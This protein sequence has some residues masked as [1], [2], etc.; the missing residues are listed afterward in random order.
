MV[1]KEGEKG[2]DVGMSAG[3]ENLEFVEELGK[4]FQGGELVLGENL[5][6]VELLC[7]FGLNSVDFTERAHAQLYQEPEG[8]FV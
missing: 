5:E 6:G 2:N 3:G 4:E 7:C 8:V 1:L